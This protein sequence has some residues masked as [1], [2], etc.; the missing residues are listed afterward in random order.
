MFTLSLCSM[1]KALLA[2]RDAVIL[3]FSCVPGAS[4]HFSDGG[5]GGGGGGV[6][7]L[8]KCPLK[9]RRRKMKI[10]YV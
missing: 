10:V 9:I 8:E 5:G 7:K 6:Q 2:I 4:I 1:R 3:E